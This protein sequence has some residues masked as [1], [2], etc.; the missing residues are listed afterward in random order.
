M[1]CQGYQGEKYCNG[2]M[3]QNQKKAISTQERLGNKH[4]TILKW[5][6]TSQDLN[7]LLHIM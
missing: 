2:I 5:P 6:S 3:V 1:N 4:W 7:L